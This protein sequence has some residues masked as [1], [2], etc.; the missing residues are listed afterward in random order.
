MRKREKITQNELTDDLITAVKHP[1]SRSKKSYTK[2][3]IKSTVIYSP[4]ALLAGMASYLWPWTGAFL[5]VLLAVAMAVGVFLSFLARRRTEHTV[6]SVRAEDYRVE[7][8]VVS[9]RNE[10]SYFDRYRG[11]HGEWVSV[12]TLHFDNGKSLRLPKNNFSW[13]KEYPMSDTAVYHCVKEGSPFYLVC[14]KDTGEAVLGY[15]KDY[16]VYEE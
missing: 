1:P 15:P 8:V 11:R 3:Y 7:S 4:F 9:G 2:S 12:Y 16:F 10:E 14:R 5:L 13:S 6:R